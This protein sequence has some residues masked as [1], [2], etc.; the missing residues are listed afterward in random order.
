MIDGE[1]QHYRTHIST[2]A[3]MHPHTHKRTPTYTHTESHIRTHTVVN[4]QY[5]MNGLVLHFPQFLHTLIKLS[6]Y[7]LPRVFGDRLTC[8]EDHHWLRDLMRSKVENVYGMDWETVCVY[9][10]HAMNISWYYRDMN[11]FFPWY[12][13]D[14]TVFLPW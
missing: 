14:I 7:Y 2:H 6:A 1:G 3:Y 12:Y 11:L 4:I 5:I 9:S 8:E 10:D 13:H